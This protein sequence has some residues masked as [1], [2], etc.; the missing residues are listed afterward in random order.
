MLSSIE[1]GRT[2]ED[3][4]LIFLSAQGL[5]LVDRNYSCARGEIDLIMRDESYLIFVE[6]RYR[7]HK[8]FGHGIE[9]VS[10]SKQQRIIHTALHYLQKNKLLDKEF[11]RF[12]VVGINPNL[13]TAE[14]F[15]WIKNAFTVKY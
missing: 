6:V 4:V 15:Q 8:E 3:E 10:K 5:T 12:D 13:P 2:A 1:R 14:K 11:C 9:T 7:H